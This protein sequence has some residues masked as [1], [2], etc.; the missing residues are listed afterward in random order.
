NIQAPSMAPPMNAKRKA[1]MG[2]SSNAHDSDTEQDIDGIFNHTDVKNI[3]VPP[4]APESGYT[5]EFVYNKLH[6][7]DI[8]HSSKLSTIRDDL[9][10]LKH[11]NCHQ[12]ED[13]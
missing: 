4:P 9:N 6:E 2:E 7:M 8:C 11:L 10:F 5:L 1:N 12:S 3:Y 13:E